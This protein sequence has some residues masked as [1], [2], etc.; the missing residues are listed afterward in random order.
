M[1]SVIRFGIASTTATTI[2][3]AIARTVRRQRMTAA[4]TRKR[5]G[6]ED[7]PVE[8]ADERPRDDAPLDLV[9]EALRPPARDRRGGD[10]T[11]SE[12][13][14]DHDSGDEEPARPVR[15]G[16][17]GGSIGDEYSSLATSAGEPRSR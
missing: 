1:P 2:A 5:E 3:M 17:C 13:H 8:E 9:A 4:S 6:G 11:S 15:A 16:G 10:E 7:E 12:H 14:R